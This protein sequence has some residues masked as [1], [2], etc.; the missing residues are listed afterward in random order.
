MDAGEIEVRIKQLVADQ[1]EVPVE[2]IDSGLSLR[3]DLGAESIAFVQLVLK[4][5]DELAIEIPEDVAAR[6]RTVADAVAYVR[7]QQR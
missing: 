1:L 7:D 6:I 5:E 3:D 2:R 4:I